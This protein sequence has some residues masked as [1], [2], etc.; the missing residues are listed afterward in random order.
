MKLQQHNFRVD[1]TGWKKETRN[2][3]TVLVSPCGGITE[4]ASEDHNK[5]Q[6]LFTWDAAMRETKKAGLRIPTD[7][8]FYELVKTKE[9]IPNLIFTGYRDTTGSFYTRG[10]YANLWSSSESGV[11][12]WYRYLN[13]AF[14]TV[15]RDIYDK[16]NGFSVRCL[17][18]ELDISNKKFTTHIT[19][20]PK[21]EM[22][23]IRGAEYEQ[24]G[25]RFKKD[26]ITIGN[27][28]FSAQDLKDFIKKARTAL[29]RYE[30]LAKNNQI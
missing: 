24:D 6:Q 19:I 10:T 11:S 9:D 23:L 18:P 2:G 4:Y 14:Y 15:A 8:E 13:S 12:A 26:D 21:S 3:V 30:R 22:K 1:S 29:A 17:E 16:A 7:K 27:R 28:N 5:G 20:T 25:V